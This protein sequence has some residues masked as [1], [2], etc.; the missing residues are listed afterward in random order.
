M[1]PGIF[2]QIGF[3]ETRRCCYRFR[4]NTN[5]RCRT[6]QG[7]LSIHNVRHLFPP[8]RV[9]TATPLSPPVLS[10]PTRSLWCFPPS[11][12]S[13]LSS[14]TSLPLR[15]YLHFARICNSLDGFAVTNGDG[16]IVGV[17]F[18]DVLAK[19]SKVAV[20][21][22]VASLAAGAGKKTFMAACTHAENLG[23][24]TLVRVGVF[25]DDA[26]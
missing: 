21:G 24:S 10:R 1:I 2:E 6:E 8:T 16:E 15:R 18:V 13:S 14:L 11:L 23:F 19:G 25:R 12:A 4:R 5:R 22:P 20:L 3:A 26:A 9:Q 7:W 17:T